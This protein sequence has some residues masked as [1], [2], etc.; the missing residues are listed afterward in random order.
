[1]ATVPL[2]VA[3]NL[4]YWLYRIHPEIFSTLLN[5]AKGRPSGLGSL[6]DDGS[7]FFPGVSVM[8]D[9]TSVDVGNFVQSD[10]G[11]I[12]TAD[13][14]QSISPDLVSLPSPQTAIGS[15]DFYPGVSPMP[16]GAADSIA[17]VGNFLD[18]ANAPSSGSSATA[19][20]TPT[21]SSVG[22]VAGVLTAGLGALA[23]V[24]AAIYKAGSP[25]ASTIGTQANRAA[26]GVNPAPITYAYNSAGQLVP[27]ISSASTGTVGALSPQTLASLGVPSSWSPYVVPALIGVLVLV[28]LSS[29]ASKR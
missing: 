7:D 26:A 3:I 20:N 29:G 27:V 6:G 17:D 25:Q 21:A 2:P 5:V 18:N 9:D 8:P 23:A 22:S 15:S 19:V 10:S 16:V 28:A 24:T 14:S 1:M 4:S 13:I 12:S 11:S